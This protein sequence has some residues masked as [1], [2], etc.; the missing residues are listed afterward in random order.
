[1][2]NKE[3]ADKWEA[4]SAAF[5]GYRREGDFWVKDIPNGFWRR[6]FRLKCRQYKWS[7]GSFPLLAADGMYL[8]GSK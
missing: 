7:V 8:V 2:I 5:A 1:M 3:T 4:D 6:L